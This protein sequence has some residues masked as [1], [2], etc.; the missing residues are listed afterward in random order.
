MSGSIARTP[1]SYKRTHVVDNNTFLSF[2]DFFTANDPT[3][4]FVDFVGKED[5]IASGMMKFDNGKI[6]MSADLR[7]DTTTGRR[8]VRVHSKSTFTG[9]IFILIWI[10]H[11]LGAAHG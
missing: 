4:G 8:S 5:A 11:P 1:P 7:N 9:G 10:I 2:F 6:L 3:H